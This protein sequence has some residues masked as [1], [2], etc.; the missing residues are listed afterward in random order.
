MIKTSDFA[1]NFRG[2]P[3][4]E[5]LQK[6]LDFQNNVSGPNFYADGFELIVN[7]PPGM[8]ETYSSEAEFLNAL[9][10]FAQVTGSGS[11]AA[12]WRIDD[13]TDLSL[14]PIVVF[15]DE[16]GYF[17]VAQHLLEFLQVLTV[18]VEL[19]G[20]DIQR[21]EGA[22]VSAASAQYR[23]WLKSNF[24][25]EAIQDATAIIAAAQ[26]K[27]QAAFEAWIGKFYS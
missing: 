16:G 8:L 18:D 14:N 11:D 12:I 13:R 24:G 3:T 17:V 5:A 19:F 15:G 7:G 9:C 10:I 22:P 6:L 25:L 23:E 1:N 21:H 2:S 20:T 27:H 4:P 26:A